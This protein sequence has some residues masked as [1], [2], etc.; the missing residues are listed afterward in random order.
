[1]QFEQNIM[2]TA[3]FL[4]CLV[5]LFPGIFG[6]ATPTHISDEN[7]RFR[8][9]HALL[10][11]SLGVVVATITS[12]PF[13]FS[14]TRHF[15]RSP[16]HHSV[17]IYLFGSLFIEDMWIKIKGYGIL[18]SGT[19]KFIHVST[20]S[21]ALSSLYPELFCGY[22]TLKYI[23][24]F[25]VGYCVASEASYLG[26]YEYCL[27]VLFLIYHE[28]YDQMSQYLLNPILST[29]HSPRLCRLLASLL[30]LPKEYDI[31][32]GQLL[33]YGRLVKYKW[34]R[35]CSDPCP[36]CRKK[37][38]EEEKSSAGK[39][40][41][42]GREGH[43]DICP[44]CFEEFKEGQILYKN[45]RNE[46]CTAYLDFKCA[47]IFLQQKRGIRPQCFNCR[48]QLLHYTLIIPITLASREYDTY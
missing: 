38:F 23:Y 17:V 30:L 8:D 10:F 37:Y 26:I 16:I 33:A 13:V 39:E 19:S 42:E 6:A 24:Y 11:N 14:L 18:R 32:Q 29:L 2:K 36:I 48:G 12:P 15:C 4:A 5:V 27:M 34:K 45:C 28:Q 47:S 9:R 31:V 1:M 44:T 43:K 40:N 46:R 3:L 35:V 22:T 25:S 20:I 41:A 21:Y 7:T